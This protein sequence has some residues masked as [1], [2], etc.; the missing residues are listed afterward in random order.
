M[1]TSVR[2]TLVGRTEKP[3]VECNNR[4][5]TRKKK[6]QNNRKKPMNFRTDILC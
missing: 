2:G 1:S 3:N 5:R 6:E 4:R